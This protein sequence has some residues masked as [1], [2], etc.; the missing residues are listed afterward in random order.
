MGNSNAKECPKLLNTYIPNKVDSSK[1][2]ILLRTLQPTGT[3]V[4]YRYKAGNL[5]RTPLSNT[6]QLHTA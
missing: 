5:E 4:Q 3:K 2:G 6:S 1:D